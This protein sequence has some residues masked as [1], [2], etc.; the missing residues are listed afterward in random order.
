MGRKRFNN[1][2]GS[3]QESVVDEDNITGRDGPVRGRLD[4]SRGRGGDVAIIIP[5]Q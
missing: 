1:R 5:A 3:P 2:Q 4:S